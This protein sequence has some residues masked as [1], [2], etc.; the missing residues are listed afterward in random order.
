VYAVEHRARAL[1]V[2][3]VPAIRDAQRRLREYERHDHGR[4]PAS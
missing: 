3:D 4:G 1:A 2:M